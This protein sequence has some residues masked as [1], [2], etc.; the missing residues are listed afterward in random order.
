MFMPS[1]VAQFQKTRRRQQDLK[2]PTQEL[3]EAVVEMKRRNRTGAA[4]ELSSRSLYP[5]ASRSTK[6]WSGGFLESIS[7]G[8]QAQRVRHGFPDLV[9]PKNSL[10]SCFDVNRSC[11]PWR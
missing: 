3:I 9:T 5:S 10:W 8:K 4:S 2:G 7:D 6:R 1:I 11:C